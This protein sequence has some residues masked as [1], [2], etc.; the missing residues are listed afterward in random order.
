MELNPWEIA[1]KSPFKINGPEWA[2]FPV[3]SCVGQ[4]IHGL[5]PWIVIP[6]V[7][8]SSPISHPIELK[9]Q[10]RLCSGFLL[11]RACLISRF[12]LLLKCEVFQGR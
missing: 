1:L 2:G 6:V 3:D 4:Q 12:G 8:G 10:A 5:S 11:F 7:V 9:H